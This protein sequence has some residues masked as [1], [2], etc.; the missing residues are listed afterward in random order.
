MDNIF[1]SQ[2]AVNQ[3]PASLLCLCPSV[4]RHSSPLQSNFVV[5]KVMLFFFSPRGPLAKKAPLK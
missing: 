5:Q 2:H 3:I 4:R 1:V